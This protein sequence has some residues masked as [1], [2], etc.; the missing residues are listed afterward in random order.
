MSKR[1]FIP[2]CA[3]AL[4]SAGGLWAGAVIDKLFG[5]PEGNDVVLEWTTGAEINM[6]VF[7]VERKMN[8]SEFFKIGTVSPRGS[9]TSYR[10]VDKTVLGK[11][12]GREYVYRLKIVDLDG[13]FAYSQTVTVVPQISSAR[14]TWGSIK[15]L[16][17]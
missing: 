16:F 11:T 17:R 7:I 6:Q 5:Y 15:A 12:T 4:L 10:F 9:G 13:T 2:V 14:E 1:I 3:F 8:G